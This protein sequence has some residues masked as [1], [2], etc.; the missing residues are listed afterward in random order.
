MRTLPS[1]RF[2][3]K[4]FNIVNEC[5]D[6]FLLLGAVYEDKTSGKDKA[7]DNVPPGG[8]HLYKWFA[9]EEAGPA[10][11]DVNC[12]PWP[13]HSH[14]I[15][16]NGINTGLTGALVICREGLSTF[17]VWFSSVFEV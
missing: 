4:Y 6:I 5:G 17:S 13:Y 11:Q 1:H 14:M 3:I 8:T 10:A 16:P 2:H 7:D 15:S 9:T 12:S